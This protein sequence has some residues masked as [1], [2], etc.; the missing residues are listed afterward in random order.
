MTPTREGEARIPVRKRKVSVKF[1]DP[2]LKYKGRLVK[3]LGTV[4]FRDR[5]EI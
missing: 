5:G 1:G 2:L 4:L 3:I